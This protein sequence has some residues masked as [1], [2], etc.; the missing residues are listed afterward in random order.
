[1]LSEL[2]VREVQIRIKTKLVQM[3]ITTHACSLIILLWHL[4]HAVNG[5]L[6]SGK[7][8]PR[9]THRA[10]IPT[11]AIIA[12]LDI[13]CGHGNVVL[14]STHNRILDIVSV[15]WNMGS[16]SSLFIFY[17]S[18]IILMVPVFWGNIKGLDS[19][20]ADPGGGFVGFGRT[21]LS[22]QLPSIS[23]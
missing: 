12:D 22:A 9:K 2:D 5:C 21:P 17:L 20:G 7:S 16:N 4:H 3:L 1:M 13:H 19:A 14:V 8:L 6:T 15:T 10:E 11:S 23:L 18:T